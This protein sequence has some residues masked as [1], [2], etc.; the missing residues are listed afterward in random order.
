[1]V[2]CDLG[3]RSAVRCWFSPCSPHSV[4]QPTASV[5]RRARH[6]LRHLVKTTP[7]AAAR[8]TSAMPRARWSSLCKPRRLDLRRT[9]PA[10]APIPKRLLPPTERLPTHRHTHPRRSGLVAGTGCIICSKTLFELKAVGISGVEETFEPQ[11]FQPFVMFFGMLFALPMYLALEARKRIRARS[12]PALRA[13][14][15]AAPP[16]T[17]RRLRLPRS[18]LGQRRHQRALTAPTLTRTPHP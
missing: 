14:L 10:C 9:V 6:N 7:W 17:V 1:M 8:R 4:A 18:Q 16:I 3:R 13:E 5:P 15:D 11:V 12:D 2:D